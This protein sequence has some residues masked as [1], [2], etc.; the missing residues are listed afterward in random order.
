M[1]TSTATILR[2]LNEIKGHNCP[3]RPVAD[4]S[5]HRV[6]RVSQ[7]KLS[8]S[9]TT[10]RNLCSS[11]LSLLYSFLQCTIVALMSKIQENKCE[12][13]MW[14]HLDKFLKLY[15]PSKWGFVSRT[16]KI[17]FQNN[18]KKTFC[19]DAANKMDGWIF[20]TS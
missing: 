4:L 3:Y 14:N 16:K 7:A 5:C 20:A 8:G 2:L 15:I 17:I 13:M 1:M 6:E 12:C 10:K 18:V 9:W 11:L 19:I